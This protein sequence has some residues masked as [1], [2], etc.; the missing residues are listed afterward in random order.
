MHDFQL[1]FTFIR[2]NLLYIIVEVNSNF[3][4]IEEKTANLTTK[5]KKK[6]FKSSN[7]TF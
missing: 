3:Y 4:Q 2:Y 1:Y 6:K 5:L 7:S